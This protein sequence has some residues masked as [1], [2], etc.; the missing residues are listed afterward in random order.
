[1]EGAMSKLI[2]A[3]EPV[4]GKKPSWVYYADGETRKGDI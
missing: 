4:L 1:M 2:C 3:A